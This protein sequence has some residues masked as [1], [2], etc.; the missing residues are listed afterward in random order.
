M[1]SFCALDGTTSSLIC[2]MPA[3][4]QVCEELTINERKKYYINGV[5]TQRPVPVASTPNRRE[6]GRAPTSP[7]CS[8]LAPALRAVTERLL[9]LS[10][11]ASV[12]APVSW[13]ACSTSGAITSLCPWRPSTRSTWTTLPSSSSVSP[14]CSRFIASFIQ[15]LFCPNRTIQHLIRSL[16]VESRCSM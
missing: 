15:S 8:S 7:T 1:T 11:T 13:D 2:G 4:C 5:V 14:H 6:L 9:L 10:S 3:A 16:S 12:T